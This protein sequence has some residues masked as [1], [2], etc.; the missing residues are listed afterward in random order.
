MHGPPVYPNPNSTNGM[1]IAAL[2]CSLA[3]LLTFISAPVGAVLG[4]VARK[5]I[6][7]KGEQGEGMAL[8]GIIIGWAVTGLYVCLCGVYIAVIASALGSAA[9]RS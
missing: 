3:G 7:A 2:V 5:Q 4:H 8:A 9:S 6:R 1:A